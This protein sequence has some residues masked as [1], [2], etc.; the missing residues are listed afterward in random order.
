MPTL[1]EIEPKMKKCSICHADKP[2]SEFY[3]LTRGYALYPYCRDCARQKAKQ[4][5]EKESKEKLNTSLYLPI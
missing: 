5:R 3:K 1:S 4:N 2:E